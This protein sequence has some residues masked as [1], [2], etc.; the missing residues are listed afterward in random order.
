[1]TSRSI[2]PYESSNRVGASRRDVLKGAGAVAGAALFGSGALVAGASTARA[3]L[4]SIVTKKIPKTGESVP[5]IGLGT[6]MTFDVKPGGQREY[7]R[8]VMRRFYEGGGRVV[9]TSPLYGLAEVSV[10]H[11]ATALGITKDLFITNKIWATGEYLS[12]NSQAMRQLEQSLTR[13]WRDK[14]EVMQVHSL[15]N[16]PIILK[17]M[18]G[19][20]KE[21]RIKY[22]GVTHHELPY[23]P[24]LAD[25]IAKAD[26]DFVQ[27]R[28]NILTRNAE[29]KIL[30]I[31]ADK[32]IAVL[33]NMPFEKARLFEAVKG[34]PLP[35]FA[36]DINC[37]NW[38]QFF[39]KYIISHPAIT[40]AIPST[41]NPD[42]Q[43]EN[44]GAL[45]GPLPDKEMREQMVKY[46]HALP[47]F[48]KIA[49]IKFYPGKEFH[50]V[51]QRP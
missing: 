6:F 33:V 9:D 40:C 11:F 31:A 30:K 32:G 26:V 15:V 47:G 25:T 7:I 42:H 16:A 2:D 38:A 13:L 36:A 45:R 14:I 19:W 37:R 20:K 18:Q 34:H 44:I 39:L 35:A 3:Q 23:F 28:Y 22:L 21:G 10:G 43:S 17:I 51:V 27:V 46:V 29:E 12:D 48:D 4:Q 5:A 8:E 41:T 24:A 49:S 50:G 1:M